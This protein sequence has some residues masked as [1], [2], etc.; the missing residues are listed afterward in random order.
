MLPVVH[1][2]EKAEPEGQPDS[3][4]VKQ[5]Q[6]SRPVSTVTVGGGFDHLSRQVGN[7]RASPNSAK[8][9]SHVQLML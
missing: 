9:R 7:W 2:V 5:Q 3:R 1:P 6:S 8:R 4:L